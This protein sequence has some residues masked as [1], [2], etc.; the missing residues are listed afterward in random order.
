M[1]NLKAVPPS[2]PRQTR[3][4][5][6]FSNRPTVRL[7]TPPKSENPRQ[8]SA[9]DGGTPKLLLGGGEKVWDLKVGPQ[10]V[11][12]RGFDLPISSRF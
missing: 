4:Q 3:G 10:I 12:P 7:G 11:K 1:P 8:N 6:H 9:W 2:Q 5:T